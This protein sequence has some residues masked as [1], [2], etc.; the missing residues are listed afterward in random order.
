MPFPSEPPGYSGGCR[1]ESA[2]VASYSRNQDGFRVRVVPVLDLMAG[3]VVHG[4]AGNR[5][6]YRPIQSPLATGADPASIAAAFHKLGFAQAYVADLDAIAGA[7]PDIASYAAIRSAGLRDLSIDAGVV[8]IDHAGRLIAALPPGLPPITIVAGL[9][10]LASPAALKALVQSRGPDGVLFSLD[11]KAGQPLTTS[12][13]WRGMT[14]IGIARLVVEGGVRRI[15]LLDLADVGTDSG[16][17]TADLVAE[18]R[19]LQPDVELWTGGGVRNR[20]DLLRQEAAGVSAV[21]VASALHNRQLGPKELTGFMCPPS[22]GSLI[23]SPTTF[24]IP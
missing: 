9:E 22:H 16:T 8:D 11:L 5:S 20:D 14:S 12:T 21:L 1:L 10:S 19:A 13:G 23:G 18:I 17:R 6:A 3:Q 7:P 24:P 15:L 2:T 4:I